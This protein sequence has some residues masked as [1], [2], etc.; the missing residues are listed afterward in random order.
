MEQKKEL[1]NSEIKDFKQLGEMEAVRK[2]VENLPKLNEPKYDLSKYLNNLGDVSEAGDSKLESYL[3]IFTS[4][5]NYLGVQLRVSEVVKTVAEEQTKR[6][7]SFA[8]KSMLGKNITE[9]KQ[10]AYSDE[11]YL[12]SVSIFNTAKAIHSSVETA[13]LSCDRAYKAVSRIVRIREMEK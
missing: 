10:L 11:L 13:F 1:D 5:Q 2:A 4:W 6:F 7:Y 12:E 9:R 3:A 8:V